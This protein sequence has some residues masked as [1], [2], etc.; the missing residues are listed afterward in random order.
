[1]L[2]VMSMIWRS[3]LRRAHALLS[4]RSLHVSAQA[5]MKSVLWESGPG[6]VPFRM[7]CRVRIAE[8]RSMVN[9]WAALFLV[10]RTAV[11]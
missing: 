11:E 10:A 9:V 7:F 6:A 1:M 2:V 3:A 8:S 4:W 5:Q